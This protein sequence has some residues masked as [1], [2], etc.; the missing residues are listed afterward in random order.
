MDCILLTAPNSKHLRKRL[1]MAA[2]MALRVKGKRPVTA[3]YGGTIYQKRP[4][5]DVNGY[6]TLKKQMRKRRHQLRAGR[7]QMAIVST[8]AISSVKMPALYMM[9]HVA[10]R[11]SGSHGRRH[12]AVR[13]VPAVKAGAMI[14][15]HTSSSE[16]SVIQNHGFGNA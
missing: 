3:T 4:K 8:V 7:A 10:K 13:S 15:A 2:L 9:A 5:I 14:A 12:T 11:C 6:V 16:V 1:P